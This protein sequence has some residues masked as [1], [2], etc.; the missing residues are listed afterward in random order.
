MIF[1]G[2]LPSA[3]VALDFNLPR[4]LKSPFSF[5]AEAAHTWQA[6]DI[7]TFGSYPQTQVTDTALLTAL[8]A[9]AL[10]RVSYGYY[11]GNGDDGSMTQSD[12]MKYADV[13]Y[14]GSKYRAVLFTS[15]RPMYTTYHADAAAGLDWD[16]SSWQDDSG[17]YTN[18]VYW[19]KY[20][21]LRWRVLDP[22]T[23][24]VMC[25]DIIDSQAYGN[26]IYSCTGEYYNNSA[27][28]AYANDYATSPMRTWLNADFYNT[29]FT[30]A[31]QS[32]I[33]AT[34]VDNS[35]SPGYSQYDSA[36]TN[37]KLFLLSYSE[38]TNAA[39]GFGLSISPSTTRYA[40]GS[41]YA[42]CQGLYVYNSSGSLYDGKSS[43][44]L[45]S[46]GCDS[47]F[48]SFVYY[49]GDIGGSGNVN[50]TF[51]GV[52][53]AFKISSLSS[54]STIPVTG[55]SLGAK[56]LSLN[57]LETSQ[58]TAEVLPFDAMDKSLTW[59]SSD[60]NVAT[61]DENG[62]V[63]AKAHG[64]ATVTVT[65][66]DGG[67]TD[68]CTVTVWKMGDI[69]TFGSYPQ[70][71]V[72][73]TA[74]LTELNAQNLSWVSYGYYSGNGDI[75]SMTQSDYM[76]YADV[77]HG[78][79][80]YR[81]VKF[82]SYR[83]YWICGTSSPTYQDSNG[84]YTNTV[85]WFKYEPLRWRVLDPSS[86]LV[87]CEDIIDSQA[88][89]NTIYHK[90]GSGYYNNPACTVYANDY[91]TSSVRT[92]L[93]DDFYN[94]AFTS[95]EQSVIKTTELDNS[96]WPGYPEYNSA[97][98]NDKLFLPSYS[99]STNAAYG[100]SSDRTNYDP[101]RRAQ[102]S[103]YAKCQ[104]L[105]VYNSPG[106]DC[107][108]NSYWFLRSPGGNSHYAC[109]V[110][111]YGYVYNYYYV[112]YTSGIGVRPAFKFSNMSLLTTI[113]V[114]GVSLGAESLSLTISETS[115]L[116]AEVS[117]LDA[118]DKSVTWAS[119]DESIAVVDENGFV[120]AKALGTATVTVT[121]TDGGFTD[122]CEVT[123]NGIDA[124][125]FAVTD[126]PDQ[127]YTGGAIEPPVEVKFNGETLTLGA[128]YTVE[129]ANNINV[130]TAA[131]TITGAGN[132]EGTKA[133]TFA[134]TAADAGGFAL[135]EITNQTYKGS[136]LTPPF[137]VKFN[138]ETL[139]LGTDYTV[140][141]ANNINVGTAAATIT[142]AGNFEGTKAVTFTITA[143]NAG[144]FAVTAI[145]N[146]TYTGGELTP[147]FEVKFNGETLTLGTDYTVE[148]T[149]NI[150]VGAATVTLTG[151]GNFEGTKDVT[152]TI[153]AESAGCF[154]VAAIPDKTY[155]GLEL[156]PPVEVR[157]SGETLTLGTDYTV[158]YTD[159]INVGT[160]T[161][162]ITGE[163]NFEGAKIVT[164][165]I[166]AESAGC[167]AVAAIPDQT[168][169]GSEITPSV[170]VKFNGETLT[171]GTDYTV[172]YTDNIN[173]GTATAT[174]TG[175]GNF[176]GAKTV[177]FTII[178]VPPQT[179]TMSGKTLKLIYED[180]ATLSVNIEPYNTTNKNVIWKS[181]NEKV[182]IVDENGKVTATGRGTATITATVEDSEVSDTCTVTVKL[183]FA[184]WIVKMLM[185]WRH[186]IMMF[187]NMFKIL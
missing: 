137:E 18:T 59:A 12:Y 11:S 42:K 85:Y 38:S 82:T 94:T 159:N 158:E 54:L 63:T 142:G 14:G 89:S 128:D 176:E 29:A 41:D 64:S 73:D 183:T 170:E 75:G 24:F 44:Y 122:T 171:L 131:A 146:Q 114:T 71:Q 127:I 4:C 78:G 57:I 116:T 141:Y 143:A 46:P 8:N 173:A 13:T 58:L 1:G 154:A 77:T 66:V 145:P 21:P 91:A 118:M 181:S 148:Y 151:E 166:T 25:E 132:F 3:L 182:A 61:V 125:N 136:E 103:D 60:T 104:G 177:T 101:A 76:K 92:W 93:N 129:Y 96:A 123:V 157:F 140:E 39:Y 167:F 174:I 98:T 50:N 133:V 126:I 113:S 108:K 68:T 26:T 120:T 102:G 84:Y 106:S 27:N 97:S 90:S 17:Y 72:T 162:T 49:P 87:M 81:A 56:S 180:T 83:P 175:E 107:D 43:W 22:A 144:S 6:G 5:G 156:T 152:F 149:D 51:I 67:F 32:L 19:F 100:F 109:V 45:R 36:S 119:S 138:G 124:D 95:A 55:V 110:Y 99:E 47:C 34:A 9:Q 40:Q 31:E 184:Q 185:F 52:R 169:T 15:F 134:I 37:D 70:T 20:E 147:P 153:T 111:Y 150:N 121:A 130:G 163:G 69:G 74:L 117:P 30:S 53:P 178:A 186:L 62:I 187:F 172:E 112:F 135:T 86:G 79:S 2:A 105:Y 179:I 23:G 88:Y 16:N 161:V 33:K 155:T 165:T 80:K 10:N 160:A 65:T 115:Q 168:Y 28:T 164:F 35:A 7:G 139:T 48:A